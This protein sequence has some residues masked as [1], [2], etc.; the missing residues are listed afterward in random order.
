MLGRRSV[1]ADCPYK[2]RPGLNCKPE[3]MMQVQPLPVLTTS[4]GAHYITPLTGCQIRQQRRR[5]NTG[6]VCEPSGARTLNQRLKR[7]LLYH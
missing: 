5:E 1:R 6:K 3:R 4:Y 7:P 2:K